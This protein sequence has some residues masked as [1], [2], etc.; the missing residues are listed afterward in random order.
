M[1]VQFVAKKYLKLK[2]V[3]IA[4]GIRFQKE[5]LGLKKALDFQS[6]PIV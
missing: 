4:L 3:Y 5:L 2:T 1:A 6:F